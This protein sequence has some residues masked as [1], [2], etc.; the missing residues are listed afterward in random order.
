MGRY[1]KKPVVV[2]AFKFGIDCMPD[3]FETAI[4]NGDVVFPV[5]PIGAKI[6]TLEGWLEADY[7]D[8]I[9]QG[10]KGEIYACK[11]DIFNMTYEKEV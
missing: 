1:R 6:R 11:P 3:W 2:E 9:I 8:Y 7:G 10:I 4:K 5:K